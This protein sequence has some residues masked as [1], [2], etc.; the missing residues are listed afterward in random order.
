MKTLYLLRHAK[1]SWDNSGMSDFERPLNDRGFATA[2]LMGKSLIEHAFLPELMIS[3]PAKRA[4]QTA[5]LVR[6]SAKI[7]V[8]LRFDGRIY[9]ASTSELLA[10]VSDV[11]GSAN[12]LMLVGHNP[13]F[14]NMVSVLTGKYETM[15]TAALAVIDLEIENWNEVSPECGILRDLLRPKEL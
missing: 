5:Q 10:V 8:E 3:S 7:E 9:A 1:S 4:R 15:P 13:S 6:E 14:E 12:S 11:I 2:P